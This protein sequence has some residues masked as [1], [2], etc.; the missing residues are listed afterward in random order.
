MQNVDE[1]VASLQK[2]MGTSVDVTLDCVGFTKSM[3]TAL[4]VTRAG[5]KVC[6]VGMGH[7]EMTL[8]IT[9]A[10]AR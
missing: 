7:N 4:K 2:I 10:A 6:L 9:P 8:P 3:Q 5:G 1:E